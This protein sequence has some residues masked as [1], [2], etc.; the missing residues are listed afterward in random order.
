MPRMKVEPIREGSIVISRE[1]LASGLNIGDDA[2]REALPPP[3][4][5]VHS[6]VRVL[7]ISQPSTA[8][9]IV[10]RLAGNYPQ[11]AAHPSL[12][13]ARVARRVY[14]RVDQRL[15]FERLSCPK[16]IGYSR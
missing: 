6:A 11:T 1:G 14:R 15:V 12:G 8:E 13:V 7:E 3:A 5:H 2:R 10:P 9:A 4:L 16:T